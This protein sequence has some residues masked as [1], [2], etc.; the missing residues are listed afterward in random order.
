MHGRFEVNN[1]SELIDV[2][3]GS[4]HERAI[5]IRLAHQIVDAIGGNASAVQ[6]S[7]PVRGLLIVD[8]G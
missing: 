2:Q 1:A 8:V 3:G 7:D 4:A 5:D 6:D